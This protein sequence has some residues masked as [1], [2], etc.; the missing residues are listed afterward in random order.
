MIKKSIIVAM[1]MMLPLTSC[2]QIK[3]DNQMEE[4]IL[5]I[6]NTYEKH[7][8]QN[9]YILNINAKG[10]S[11]EILI[12]DVQVYTNFSKTKIRGLGGS[13]HINQYILEKGK[14]NV[15][16]NIFPATS[17]KREMDS[18]L[19]PNLFCKISIEQ[20]DFANQKP[21]D[22]TYVYEYEYKPNLSLPQVP[23]TTITG[24]FAA[25]VSYSIKG[26]KESV[27]LEDEDHDKLKEEVLAFYQSYIKIFEDKNLGKHLESLYK[28]ERDI[29]MTNYMYSENDSKNVLILAKEQIERKQTFL[30]ISNY[31]M[32]FY[33]NGKIVCFARID[34]RFR[35]ESV[36]IGHKE[37]GGYKIYLIFLHRPK[38]GA[39]LEVIR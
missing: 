31:E 32:R 27:N 29:M 5:N 36:L 18:V 35:G 16:I 19:D 30:P 38:P 37:T 25:D 8:N 14:Q 10:C 33:G 26:W 15:K 4:K 2:S 39:P 6:H 1:G 9:S 3:T 7:K 23:F 28:R 12:N 22:F 21:K 11:L 13:I 24:E 34:N 17:E 20:G